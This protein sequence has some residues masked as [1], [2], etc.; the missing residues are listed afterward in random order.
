MSKEIL[1]IFLL[2]LA[3]VGIVI[4]TTEGWLI[5]QWQKLRDWYQNYRFLRYV[6]KIKKLKPVEKIR[7]DNLVEELIKIRYHQQAFLNI[8]SDEVYF[9]KL[10]KLHE[11]EE[12]FPQF[13]YEYSPTQY[14]D[15]NEDMAAKA[16]GK[17]WDEMKR[18]F[19]LVIDQTDPI[20]IN[21][22]C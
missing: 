12:K 4:L 14:H 18:T 3:W 2:F 22:C 8:V 17:R 15:F 6:K 5:T 20:D 16:Y 11:L 10:E 13:V 9:D 19:D 1:A 7:I 21:Y